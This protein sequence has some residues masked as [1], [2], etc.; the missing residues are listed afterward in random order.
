M[1][2]RIVLDDRY[3]LCT[4]ICCGNSALFAAFLH[5]LADP[6]FESKARL[7]AADL[8]MPLDLLGFLPRYAPRPQMIRHSMVETDQM[9]DLGAAASQ[10][11]NT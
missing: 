9:I 6:T 4:S 5:Q 10:I 3:S 7:D 8:R 1:A 11:R 2:T